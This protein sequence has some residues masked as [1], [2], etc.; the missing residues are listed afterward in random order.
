M[1]WDDLDIKLPNPKLLVL[2]AILP[3]PIYVIVNRYLLD[4]NPITTPAPLPNLPPG[5]LT[6]TPREIIANADGTIQGSFVLEIVEDSAVKSVQSQGTGG[7][8]YIADL[9]FAKYPRR[10]DNG[11]YPGSCHTNAE[12]NDP[13]TLEPLPQDWIGYCAHESATLSSEQLSAP[14]GRC[15]IRPGI[16]WASGNQTRYCRRSID[17]EQAGAPWTPLQNVDL[18]TIPSAI[19]VDGTPLDP[20]KIKWR[21]HTCLNIYDAGKKTDL[22]GCGDPTKGDSLHRDGPLYPEP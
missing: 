5:Y 12:C 7:A 10:K 13:T 20:T 22:Q 18:P 6:N 19:T 11:Q 21:V 8:C 3:L 15:W 14:V 16:P 9:E 17:P 2:I 1:K 4:P